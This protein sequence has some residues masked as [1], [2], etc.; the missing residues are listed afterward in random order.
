M[1]Q[2]VYEPQLLFEKPDFAVFYKP[3][4]RETVSQ[5]G[6]PDFLALAGAMLPG[7]MLPVHRLDRD[8]SGAL[9]LARNAGA[10]AALTGMFRRREVEKTYLGLC[11]GEPSNR[12]GT[13]NRA[14]SKWSGGRRPVRVLRKGGL[15]AETAYRVLAAGD[16]EGMRISLVAFEPRQGR[17]HQIRVHASSLGYPLLGDDQYG[18]RAANKALKD[19]CDLRRQA[20]HSYRLAFPWQGGEVRVASPLSSD[21]GRVAGRFLGSYPLPE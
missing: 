9:L 6:E 4:G 11:L 18:D 10:E 8:T 12:T 3:P 13:I 1:F 2:P 16:A 5:S 21:M 14:L 19:L 17:T 7:G 20:L 15:A